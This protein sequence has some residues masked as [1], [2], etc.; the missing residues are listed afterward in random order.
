MTLWQRLKCWLGYHA[1]VTVRPLLIGGHL[2]QCVFCDKMMCIHHG[3][4]Q[5]I[6]YDDDVKKWEAE[7]RALYAR[8]GEP[9]P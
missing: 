9:R 5:V 2:I 3:R 1:M 6:D 7:L 8:F 4:Q